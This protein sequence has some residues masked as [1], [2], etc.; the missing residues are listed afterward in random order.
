MEENIT[1]LLLR[2]NNQDKVMH[3]F[4]KTFLQLRD[5]FLSVF[6]EKSS[7]TF[8]F[9]SYLNNK[10]NKTWNIIF[11]EENDF[12]Y[13]RRLK[14]LKKPAIF[15]CEIDEE[16]EDFDMEEFDK[17]NLKYIQEKLGFELKNIENNSDINKIKAELERKNNVLKNLQKRIEYLSK[18]IQNLKQFRKIDENN[19]LSDLMEADDKMKENQNELD[20]QLKK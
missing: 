7:K 8:L 3:F 15:I 6:N 9:K 14:L 19:N 10:S 11:S 2:Y 17:E 4:P 12:T 1:S 20:E 16:N 13:I 18:D 5:F